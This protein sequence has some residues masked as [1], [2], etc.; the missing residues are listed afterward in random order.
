MGAQ[1]KKRKTP[2]LIRRNA[3]GSMCRVRTSSLTPSSS[4]TVRAA[5]PT[6]ALST[7]PAAE[8][9][10]TS[11]TATSTAVT[12]A[13]AAAEDDSPA[14][15][16]SSPANNANYASTSSADTPAA[17]QSSAVAS[18]SSYSGGG[19]SGWA[20]PGSK[21]GAAWP[22][23]DWASAGDADYIGNY[24]GSKTSWYYTWSP[25]SIVSDA[26]FLRKL[27]QD[28]LQAAGD[29]LGLEFV[30]MLWGPHQVSD[31]HAQQANWPK[32]VKN[33]LFFNVS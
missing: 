31:F 16:S 1:E 10:T 17:H 24:I 5:A 3:D 11:T 13:A 27:A 32:T 26:S 14:A 6:T 18:T 21:L 2:G 22:N 23:G 30:P 15:A 25:H 9:P 7:T 12:Q 8:T 29:D 20:N 33:A 4:T 28:R 19:A